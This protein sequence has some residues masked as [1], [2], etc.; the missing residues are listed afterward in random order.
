MLKGVVHRHVK[1]LEDFGWIRQLNN[2]EVRVMGLSRELIGF[3]TYQL[4]WFT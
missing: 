3:T 4:P 2:D 1:T